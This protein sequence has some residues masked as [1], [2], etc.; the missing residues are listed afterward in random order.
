MRSID[1]PVSTTNAAV[2]AY[3]EPALPFLAQFGSGD[4]IGTG[5]CAGTY[6]AA[7]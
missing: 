7:Y 3:T 2:T 4:A 5:V 6:T 1:R